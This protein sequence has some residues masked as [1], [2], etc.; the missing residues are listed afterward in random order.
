MLVSCKEG[1]EPAMSVPHL[2]VAVALAERERGAVVVHDDGK[3]VQHERR[4]E[5]PVA[6]AVR[7]PILAPRR[8]VVR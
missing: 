4:R 7:R 1:S 8:L 6:R 5:P 2:Q 3:V